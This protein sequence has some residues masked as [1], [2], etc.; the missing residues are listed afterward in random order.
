LPY[1]PGEDAQFDCGE[2]LV[3]MKGRPLTIQLLVG[4][5]CYSKAPFLMAFP[6]QQQKAFAFFGGVPHA[7]WYD[8]LRPGGEAGKEGSGAGSLHRLSEPL[9]IPEPLLQSGTVAEYQWELSAWIERST[10]YPIDVRVLNYSSLGF[11][12]AAS[13]G[14]LLFTRDEELW[15]NFHEQTWTEHLD[16]APLSSNSWT[17]HPSQRF[18]L[19][20]G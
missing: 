12:R 7:I 4:R 11:R 16:F 20:H 3:M 8:H 9:P 10:L 6:N 19:G 14:P 2:A 13:G 1:E 18:S 15:Y 5:L 17:A